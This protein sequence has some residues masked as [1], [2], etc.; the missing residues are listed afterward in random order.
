MANVMASVT[1]NLLHNDLT[2]KMVNLLISM[3]EDKEVPERY[4]QQIMKLVRC[5]DHE[6]TSGNVAMEIEQ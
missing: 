6:E 5:N 1:V 2:H 4:R 3:A